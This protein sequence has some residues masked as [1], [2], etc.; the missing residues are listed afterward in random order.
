MLS[1]GWVE[2]DVDDL[3]SLVALAAGVSGVGALVG[4]GQRTRSVNG[5][6]SAR[7]QRRRSAT[8]LISM[9]TR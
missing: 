7:G 4:R 3:E 8:T 1:G 5:V 9:A 6:C 2:P